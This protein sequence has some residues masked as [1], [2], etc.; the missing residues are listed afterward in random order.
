MAVAAALLLLD[1]FSVAA[2]LLLLDAFSVACCSVAAGCFFCCLL[3][4]AMLITLLN[5]C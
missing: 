5:A 2:T 3:A 1:A 4:F